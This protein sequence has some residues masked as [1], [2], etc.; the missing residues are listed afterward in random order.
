MLNHLS[1]LALITMRER[2]RE[3]VLQGR[4]KQNFVPY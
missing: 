2:E 1:E 3:R 4:Q